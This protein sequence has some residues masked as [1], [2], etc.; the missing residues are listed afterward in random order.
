MA[1]QSGGKFFTSGE[2]DELTT[3]LKNNN[4]IKPAINVQEMINEILNLKGLF[5]VLLVIMSSEWLLRK[6]WGLY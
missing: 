6:Y 5:F 1:G 3:E 2:L 4:N